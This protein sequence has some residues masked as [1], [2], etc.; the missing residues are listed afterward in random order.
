MRYYGG[1]KYIDKI[2]LLAEERA[3]DLFGL[4]SKEW[5]VNMQSLSG[6]PA[7][8]CVYGGLLPL[9]SNALSMKLNSGG[10]LSHGFMLPEK[11]IHFSSK[12]WN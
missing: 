9:G 5:G 7:N 6:S 4:N 8:F 2:E 12:L 11:K 3:L 1:N 10:H